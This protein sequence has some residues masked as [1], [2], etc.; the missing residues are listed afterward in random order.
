MS[1]V[2]GAVDV[3]R[4]ASDTWRVCLS[5]VVGGC[6]KCAAVVVGSTSADERSTA[7]P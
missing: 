2:T 7:G 3:F 1:P 5:S 4:V 6:T